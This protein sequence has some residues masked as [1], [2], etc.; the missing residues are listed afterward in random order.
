MGRRELLR[1]DEEEKR[2]GRISEMRERPWDGCCAFRGVGISL[3]GMV[4][5]GMLCGSH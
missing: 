5:G 4:V 3:P 2:N 1:P